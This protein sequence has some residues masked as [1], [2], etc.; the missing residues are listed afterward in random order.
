MPHSLYINKGCI[1]PEQGGRYIHRRL[2][3]EGRRRIRLGGRPPLPAGWAVGELVC[4]PFH[5]TRRIRTL[6]LLHLSSNS[7]CS[8]PFTSILS[9][10]LLPPHP[11]HPAHT[12]SRAAPP[13]PDPASTLPPNSLLL[14]GRTSLPCAPEPLK[15]ARRS[16]HIHPDASDASSIMASFHASSVF[17]MAAI[18]R[19][20][21]L[22]A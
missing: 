21:A 11:N 3:G 12:H 1:H 6:L 7:L 19:P 2:S 20:G 17:N 18:H 14:P 13:L 10:L 8:H 16:Q 15:A 4:L 22:L 9:P 5:T